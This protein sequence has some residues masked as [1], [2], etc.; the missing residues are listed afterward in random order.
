RLHERRHAPAGA[1]SG[2]EQQMLV[3]CRALMGNPRL[4]IVDEPTEGLSPQMVDRVAE[5]L[6]RLK[7]EGL[8]MLLV[9]QK[10]DIAL[11]LADEVLVIGHGEARFRGSVPQLRAQPDVID[12]WVGLA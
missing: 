10:L 7:R 9:E 4:L 12:T 11:D 2:G 5:T 8:A 3:L 1:L 6:S